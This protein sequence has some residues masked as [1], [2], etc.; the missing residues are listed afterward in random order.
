MANV[1]VVAA[2]ESDQLAGQIQTHL[3]Y[4]TVTRHCPQGPSHSLEN[5][6][7]KVDHEG[8]ENVHLL[9]SGH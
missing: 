7:V 2:L 5:L 3:G 6:D 4:H 1:R 9:E 8:H